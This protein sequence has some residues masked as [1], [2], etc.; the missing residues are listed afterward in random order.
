MPP[1]AAPAFPRAKSSL[2]PTPP[3]ELASATRARLVRFDVVEAEALGLVARRALRRGS[4]LD[5]SVDSEVLS[6]EL[7]LERDVDSPSSPD[8]ASGPAK[9]AQRCRLQ[10]GGL[11][12]RSPGPAARDPWQ[13]ARL[14]PP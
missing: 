7:E 8:P 13:P 6:C 4:S 1:S 3:R 5:R 12:L 14:V 9:K 11:A 10:A 2:P